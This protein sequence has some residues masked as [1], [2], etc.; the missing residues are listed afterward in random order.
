MLPIKPDLCRLPG[1]PLGLTSDRVAVIPNDNSGPGQFPF[2][3]FSVM[4]G[5][6]L[7]QSVPV[8]ST[9]D[10]KFLPIQDKE[11]GDFVLF[12]RVAVFKMRGRTEGASGIFVFRWGM[13]ALSDQP[14]ARFISKIYDST[15][16]D[17]YAKGPDSTTLI[18]CPH[19]CPYVLEFAEIAS[20]K[21][22][23]WWEYPIPH[24]VFGPDINDSFFKQWWAAC[25]LADAENILFCST[26][27]PE[28]QDRMFELSLQ[29]MPRVPEEIRSP[30]DFARDAIGCYNN[31]QADIKIVVDCNYIYILEY[32]PGHRH[33]WIS[34][35]IVGQQISLGRLGPLEC[36]VFIRQTLCCN[37]GRG[38]ASAL[39]IVPTATTTRLVFLSDG[40]PATISFV[41]M[42][43][44][45]PRT[46][47]RD[48][49]QG[50]I[51]DQYRVSYSAPD[52]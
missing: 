38:D 31:V 50:I 36:D 33:L 7:F 12:P 26:D 21:T 32:D 16:C 22:L 15:C 4:R 45:A 35:R 13:A 52:T 44:K 49:W 37:F 43:L 18:L 23:P 51:T 29:E 42:A 17:I 5:T 25:A 2:E 6:P 3:V 34:Y 28:E 24:I 11:K 10:D 47:A 39:F 9:D 19:G 1:M 48:H 40:R 41:G 46:M 8:A 20:M 14:A 30:N 27:S